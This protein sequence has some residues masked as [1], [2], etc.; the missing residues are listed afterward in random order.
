MPTAMCCHSVHSIC[1][2]IETE[3]KDEVVSKK[4]YKMTQK[5]VIAPINNAESVLYTAVNTNTVLKPE[6]KK[7]YEQGRAFKMST[8]M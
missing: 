8:T 5:A 6:L 2:S 3:H 1:H 7:H 4:E